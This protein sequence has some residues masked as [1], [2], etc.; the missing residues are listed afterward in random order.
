MDAVVDELTLPRR[1]DRL[2]D[3]QHALLPELRLVGV[4]DRLDLGRMGW[5]IEHDDRH[6]L[7]VLADDRAARRTVLA[8][9]IEHAEAVGKAR[10]HFFSEERRPLLIA[11]G[12]APEIEVDL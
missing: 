7:A 3:A 10:S 4:D 2:L 11:D 8:R 6:Q 1:A 9:D 5:R 12:R